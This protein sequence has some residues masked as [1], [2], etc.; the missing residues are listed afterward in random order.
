RIAYPE[1]LAYVIYTS[2]STGKPKGVMIEHRAVVNRLLW[3]QSHYQLT[4]K[5]VVLQKT[6]FCFDVSV[7]E[8]LWT[9][10]CGSKLVFA[11]PQGHKDLEYLKTLITS[12]KV[13]TIHF[14][15]SMLRVFLDN[16]T[17]GDCSSLK[18]VLCSGEDLALKEI[19]LFKDKF[20]NVRLDN[21]YGPTEAA[22]DVSSWKVPLET[23]F[24]NVLI[25]TPVANTSL[26][27]VDKFQQ[28]L[29][30]GVIGE[31]CIGGVQV[32]RGYLNNEQLTKE[33]FIENPFVEGERIYKTGDLARWMPDGNIE[34]IGRI[35]NQVKI[36]GY[37]IEL[38]EIENALTKIKGVSACCVLAKE[39]ALGNKRLVGYLVM[40]ETIDK[41][42]IQ[43][44]L[45][46]S[47][48]EYMVPT[49]WVELESM[50]LNSSGK[51]DKKALPDPD[52][53]LL[54]NREY[55]PPRNQTEQTLVAI[56]Q[57]LLGIDKVGVHDNFFELGGHSLLVVQLISRLQKQG[58]HLRVKDIFETPSISDLNRK[59]TSISDT[60]SV[61]D[62]GITTDS[63]TIT[64]SMVPLLNFCQED[65]DKIIAA[66]PGG[67]SNIED[68]YPLAPLQQGIH[69]HHLMSSPA[70][71]D[72][73]ILPSLLSFSNL[74]KRSEFIEALQFIV[75]RHDVLR[76]CIISESLP[77]PVQVVLR[78]AHLTIEPLDLKDAEDILSE[79]KAMTAP[80]NQW[81]D[82][83]KAPLLRLKTAEETESGSYYLILNQH[84][85]ILDHVG[86]EKI[87][88]EITLYLSGNLIQLNTPVL[89]RNFIGHAL[90]Q[91]ATNDS[92]AY[93]KDRYG[94]IELPTYPFDLSNTFGDGTQ[95]KEA[96]CIV[97]SNLSRQIRSISSTLGITPAV[98]FHAAYGLVV[99]R[100]SNTNYAI[101]G[102]LFS[103]RL[104][105]SLGAEDSLGL[106]INTL[107][108]LLKLSGSLPEYLAKVKSQ[109]Q[110]LLPYEQTPL[111]D[112]QH[113][114]GIPNDAPLFSALLNYRHSSPMPSEDVN[115]QMELGITFLEGQE[116]TNYPFNVSVDDLGTDFGLTA[117]VDPS[118][119]PE[120]I[121][122]YMQQALEKI[123]EGL[124][125]ETALE[126]SS[127]GI[128][129]EQET[130]LL[131]HT[132]N[133]TQVSY[134]KDKTLVDL[135]EQQVRETPENIAVVFENTQLSYQQLDQQSN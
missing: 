122:S 103:G 53:S 92:K 60:Y 24:T 101:F 107:P 55:V 127:L 98:F 46:Q 56:W 35:D 47:L 45:K 9:I 97:S 32:A 121:M 75:A 21:L 30:I 5:D 86:L 95:I 10:T 77:H 129:P 65:L 26:Y 22:I 131:L 120:R 27:I 111:S 14:V 57:E 94:K 96:N 117:Q 31:L 36:R 37:R 110:N 109:L 105:G 115:P 11:K 81:M 3:T 25:G 68:I 41:K 83:T 108:V 8:L 38:G 70:E 87:V 51:L 67:V 80:G 15:P 85:L 28:L 134:P 54:S 66:V 112:I 118:L 40:G 18:R 44:S 133:D 43:D 91:Q 13:T 89:Y 39:D 33:K 17:L 2:G 64:P 78:E 82:L 29:P 61:P 62:N 63:D 69:F 126:V 79:L 59:L 71:G 104:Q 119:D 16:I 116:R 12:H 73:Y 124:E 113:W 74:E 4:D 90:H 52:T 102:S 93:F 130:S 49:I 34:F 128:L 42:I 106:F 125:N 58:F 100:C 50:P 20:T 99:G 72:P 1:N 88:Q 19:R 48:P 132:F 123:L 84:H 7:W 135:F 76:T 23:S 6:S 114:S